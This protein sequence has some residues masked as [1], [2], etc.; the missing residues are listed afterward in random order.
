MQNIARHSKLHT[1]LFILL[2]IALVIVA[3]L[4]T[5]VRSHAANPSGDT[6]APTLGAKKTWAGDPNL[7][8]GSTGGESQ[9]I[10]SGPAKNCDTYSLTVQGTPSD[11]N[12]KLL[13]IQIAWQSGAHDYDLYIH[14]GDLT[15]PIAAQG[16]NSGQPGTSETGYLDS[17]KHGCRFVFSSRCLR[18][19]HPDRY[20]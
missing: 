14:K 3:S 2:C 15:G 4:A 13:Q 16:T 8:T 7:A 12:G 1:C 11:W 5:F 9:C 17:G 19:S 6:I 10:D 18:G 20:L